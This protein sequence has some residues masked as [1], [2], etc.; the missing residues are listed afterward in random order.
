MKSATNGQ[1]SPAFLTISPSWKF[2]PY[3][4][5][6]L[7]QRR[8]RLSNP[9]S[10]NEPAQ[11][12]APELFAED[13]DHEIFYTPPTSPEPIEMA[14]LHCCARY[15]NRETRFI[16]GRKPSPSDYEVYEVLKNEVIPDDFRY[17]LAWKD[18]MERLLRADD[19]TNVMSRLFLWCFSRVCFFRLLPPPCFLSTLLVFFAVMNWNLVLNL[20]IIL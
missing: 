11:T 19:L 1:I 12:V 8:F 14:L 20:L 13:D 17:I 16:G 4:I 10:S 5:H 2:S 15:S 6:G 9:S 7:Q 18:Q 3:T